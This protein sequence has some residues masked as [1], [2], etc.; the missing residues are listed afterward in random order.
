ME[1]RYKGDSKS[2]ANLITLILML[3]SIPFILLS[4][5]LSWIFKKRD[6]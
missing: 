4:M 5:I 6:V 3:V 1:M 2:T